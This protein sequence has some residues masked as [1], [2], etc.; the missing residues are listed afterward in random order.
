M[1]YDPIICHRLLFAI[2]PP[3]EV[4]PQIGALFGLPGMNGR[5]VHAQTLHIAVEM[6]EDS[7]F[8][9]AREVRAALDAGAN[10]DVEPFEI[11]LDRL[12]GS[13]GSVALRP[14]R[15]LPMLQHLHEAVREAR[16]EAGLPEREGYRFNPVMTLV[17]RE[18]MP[19][20]RP[21]DPIVWRVERLELIDS[22]VGSN[23]QDSIGHWPLTAGASAPE[24][25]A[26]RQYA[27]L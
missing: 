16:V 6:L 10:V 8:Y 2:R 9:P 3:A 13:H 15:R 22:L 7:L 21:I 27:F 17:H 5:K 20:T 18:G 12:A 24:P 23:R 19:F 1:R 26:P 11:M 4:I 14:S 25:E